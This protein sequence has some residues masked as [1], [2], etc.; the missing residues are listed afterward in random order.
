MTCHTL[1]S[2]SLMYEADDELMFT[3]PS[4]FKLAANLMSGE[5]QHP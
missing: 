3:A 1:V 4:G 2:A 5:C